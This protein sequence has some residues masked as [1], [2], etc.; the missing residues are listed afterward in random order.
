V[1]IGIFGLGFEFMEWS[2]GNGYKTG[3]VGPS[4]DMSDGDGGLEAILLLLYG[5]F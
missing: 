1:E 4:E 2:A 3:Q 5:V